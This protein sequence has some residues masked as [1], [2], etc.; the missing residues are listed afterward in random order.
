MRIKKNKLNLFLIPPVFA[1]SDQWSDSIDDGVVTIQGV[2]VLFKLFLNNIIRIGGIA[3]FIMILIG[4]FKYLTS[5]GDPKKSE[6]AKKV[7]TYAVMGLGL[8]IGSWLILNF[9]KVFTGIDVTQFI[10]PD[11]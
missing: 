9:V 7:L 11:A 3:V 6:E 8:M 2:N 10:F 1:Q 4:G 5:G